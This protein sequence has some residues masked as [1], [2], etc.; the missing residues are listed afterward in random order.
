MVRKGSL[1]L[2]LAVSLQCASC[3]VNPVTGENQL[4]LISEAQEQQIGLKYAPAVAKQLGGPIQNTVLQN[5]VNSIGQRVAAAGLAHRPN[6]QFRYIALDDESINAMALP[7]GYVFITKGLLL[8]L[9]TPDQLA[10]VLAHETAHVTA[11]HTAIAMSNQMG[12]ELILS[13]AVG[14]GSSQGAATTAQLTSQ[15]MTLGHSRSH[16]YQ[17]DSIGTDYLVAA[18]FSYQ[19][20]IETMEIL[21]QQNKVRQF[22]YFSTHPDPAKRLE[23]I[24]QRI[25]QKAYPATKQSDPSNYREFVLENLS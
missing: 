6:L 22:E 14:E 16:E 20:M 2:V 8:K 18:G 1:H 17:A 21:Q 19:A 23:N 24:R 11:R 4:M 25:A 12:M 15:I 5:Y 3:A 10:A 9:T 13:L 7:G